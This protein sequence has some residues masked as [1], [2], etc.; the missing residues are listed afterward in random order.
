MPVSNQK[1]Q[2]YKLGVQLEV[3]GAAGQSALK[4][5]ETQIT[6]T[7]GGFKTLSTE[8]QKTSRDLKDVETQTTKNSTAFQKLR[9]DFKDALKG[10]VEAGKAFG[11]NFGSSV[12]DAVSNIGSTIG[13][14]VGT[15]LLP[16]I[17]T[18]VGAAVGSGV[19]AMVA[20]MAGPLIERLTQGLELNKLLERSR[21]TFKGYIGDEKEAIAHLTELKK[22]AIDD[23]LELPQLLTASE[24]LQDFN[25]NV[26]TG[27]TNIKLVTLEL[28]A[29]AD[30][31]ASFGGSQ[32][33]FDKVANSLGLLAE[34]GEVAGKTL[35]KLYQQGVP[36][37]K[38]LAEETG[39][40]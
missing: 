30:Q 37:W 36:V 14:A 13:S 24:R 7:A 4:T 5:F 6:K 8:G 29:A 35:N 33:V 19:D 12:K 34:K 17:G 18:A 40:S 27:R 1:I 39:K 3:D 31:A 38:Y 16:G 9:A 32:E 15:I 26:E 25:Y 28:R 2:A 11:K 22:L 20:K 21:L 23:G 10:D